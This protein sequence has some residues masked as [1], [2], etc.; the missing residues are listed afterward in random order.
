VSV[1]DRISENP[2][3]N[4]VSDP[5]DTFDACSLEIPPDK[6]VIQLGAGQ[7]L[8]HEHGRIGCNFGR[9]PKLVT[10]AH[11]S[12]VNRANGRRRQRVDPD[13]V[14][15]V[16]KAWPL[17][18]LVTERRDLQMRCD[19]GHLVAVKP[20]ELRDARAREISFAVVNDD[21]LA[22]RSLVLE[23]DLLRREH[24]VL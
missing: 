20:Q 2:W 1:E 13:L 5:V 17:Q 14:Q 15:A 6:G 21:M 24:K 16:P 23:H 4:A 8:G 12:L 18:S 3:C 7:P 10:D 22:R 9:L 19:D 11:A